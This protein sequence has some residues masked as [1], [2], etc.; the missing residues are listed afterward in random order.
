MVG[1]QVDRVLI[2]L[3]KDMDSL[4]PQ[5]WQVDCVAPSLFKEEATASATSLP[6]WMILTRIKA[7]FT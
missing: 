3:K 6:T 2:G 7:W 4:S 1:P 5:R